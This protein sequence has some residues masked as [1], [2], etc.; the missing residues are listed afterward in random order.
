MIVN[1]PDEVGTC[2]QGKEVVF[3]ET[4]MRLNDPKSHAVVECIPV[5]PK[6]TVVKASMTMPVTAVVF[7]EGMSGFMH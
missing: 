1:S 5:P 6:V 3:M 7:R 2:A 4:A